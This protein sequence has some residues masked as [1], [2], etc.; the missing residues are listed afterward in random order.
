M[1][2]YRP[3]P[4]RIEEANIAG[5]IDQIHSDE[6]E[7]CFLSSSFAHAQNAYDTAIEHGYETGIA[8]D[9][10][11]RV[12]R[13][14][15]T[16]RKVRY[17]TLMKFTRKFPNNKIELRDSIITI[18]DKRATVHFVIGTSDCILSACRHLGQALIH[19]S[20]FMNKVM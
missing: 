8:E 19:K 6:Y 14:T 13:F 7:G 12:L 11:Y 2:T 16:I 9:C 20:E 17:D 18:H 5:A 4:L 3:T 1:T 10:F 15:L